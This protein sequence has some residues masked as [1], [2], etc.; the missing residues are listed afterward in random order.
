MLSLAEEIFLLSLLDK[1]DSIRIPS[2]ISLPFVLTGAVLTELAL[3]EY[4]K[5]E[6]RRLVSCVDPEQVTNEPMRY[7]IEKISR[8]EKL[9]KLDHWVYLLSAKGKRVSKDILASLIEK[10]ILAEKDKNHLWAPPPGEDAPQQLPA[11]YLLKREIRDAV[12]GADSLSERTLARIEFMEACDMLDHLFTKDEI[13]AVRKKIKILRGSSQLPS[14]F[15]NLL[16]QVT[17]AIDYAITAAIT[18]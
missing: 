5:V 15:L 1:K 11:R 16:D 12:F 13:I 7:A 17:E 6:D 14:G 2:S 9:K 3:S 10:G 8:S 18:A 4:V